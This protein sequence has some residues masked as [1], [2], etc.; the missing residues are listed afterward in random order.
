VVT[1]DRKDEFTIES[2]RKVGKLSAI[3]ISHDNSGGKNA[4][5]FLEKIQ[6]EDLGEKQVYEF[7]CNKWLSKEHDDKQISRDL[8]CAHAFS[9]YKGYINKC[10]QMQTNRCCRLN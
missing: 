3:N 6:V 7:P 10:N 4:A 9:M 2:P 8:K 5:W 1:I